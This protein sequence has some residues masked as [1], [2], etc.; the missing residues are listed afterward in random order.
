MP[1]YIIPGSGTYNDSN[2]G[3]EA[4]IPGSGSFDS[5]SAGQEITTAAID[6]LHQHIIPKTR[7]IVSLVLDLKDAIQQQI[8][9]IKGVTQHV[10]LLIRSVIHLNIAEVWN[11]LFNK[12]T[13]ATKDVIHKHISPTGSISYIISLVANS[14][15][16]KRIASIAT[17]VIPVIEKI[18]SFIIPGLGTINDQN[19][20][21]SAI[22]PSSGTYNQPNLSGRIRLRIVNAIH[23]QTV[24]IKKLLV[25][26]YLKA[27]SLIH[28]NIVK[29]NGLSSKI[30]LGL[31]STIHNQ[32]TNIQNILLDTILLSTIDAI[33]S[34]ILSIKSLIN[35]YTFLVKDAI[36]TQISKIVS[37]VDGY[38][39]FVRDAF[40][41]Q[42]SEVVNV[43]EGAILFIINTFHRVMTIEKHEGVN[44]FYVNWDAV[45]D[46]DLDHYKVFWGTTS[47]GPYNNNSGDIGDVLTYSLTL[48]NDGL[49][50]YIIVKAYD[51]NN[52]ESDASDELSKTTTSGDGSL[53][54]ILSLILD[55]IQFPVSTISKTISRSFPLSVYD[56]LID[57]MHTLHQQIVKK[58]SVFLSE[59]F[60][61]TKDNFIK[62]IKSSPLRLLLDSILYV[63]DSIHLQISEIKLNANK[64]YLFAKGSIHQQVST[65]TG[66]VSLVIL[67]VKTLLHK[68][69]PSDEPVNTFG[70]V[71]WESDASW[72]SGIKWEHSQ[73]GVKTNLTLFL[74][75]KQVLNDAIHQHIVLRPFDILLSFSILTNDVIHKQIT[76]IKSNLVKLILFSKN[77]LHQQVIEIKGLAN[78]SSIILKD[79]IHKQIT[80][81]NNLVLRIRQIVNDTI[82]KHVISKPLNLFLILTLFCKKTIHI[83]ITEIKSFIFNLLTLFP[84]K[85]VHKHLISKPIRL[86]LDLFLR[87]YDAF[88]K[89]IAEIKLNSNKLVLGIYNSIHKQISQVDELYLK[90]MLFVKNVIHQI[91]GTKT[92]FFIKIKQLITDPLHKIGVFQ[93]FNLSIKLTLFTKNVIQKQITSIRNL[94]INLTLDTADSFNK[95]FSWRTLL[96]LR[97]LLFTKKT[98]HRIITKT[99]FPLLLKIKQFAKNA[100]HKHIVSP[101]LTL[102][103]KIT[104]FAKK[105]IHKYISQIVY[106]K[107]IIPFGVKEFITKSGASNY[108]AKKTS[109]FFKTI[110]NINFFK[111]KK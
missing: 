35:Y 23:K 6:T 61:S 81:I 45:G 8:V 90:I 86:F 38:I 30:S 106:V 72:D 91:I 48:P 71:A 28:H 64:L 49:T 89:Q 98:I 57:V 107:R 46:P 67:L 19:L 15:V 66:V 69:I 110:R 87:S 99:N 9:S 26:T 24:N 75:I 54:A 31:Q 100:I 101:R 92:F 96:R 51:T 29:I 65:I 2:L 103:L 33:H 16:H 80:E 77:A 42:I 94:F 11:S 20:E 62:H 76:E 22:I 32:I 74:K 102:F 50:Y 53:K 55:I 34:Q 109:Y 43:Y 84:L 44:S 47:G 73:K 40:N 10:I 5:D 37:V 93:P 79:T 105:T 14:T 18:R 36:H 39:L 85:P 17:L 12:Y 60:I 27:K 25:N 83:H 108:V 88:N 97:I 7:N 59:L 56:I 52:F 70:G 78:R 104:L 111:T 13:F 41:K 3:F 82:S 68:V 4:I 63:Y 1:E 58:S 21:L 95:V